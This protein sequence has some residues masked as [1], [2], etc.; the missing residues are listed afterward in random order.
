MH[1]ARMRQSAML[2]NVIATLSCVVGCDNGITTASTLAWRLSSPSAASRDNQNLFMRVTRE[3][4]LPNSAHDL[5]LCVS[6]GIDRTYYLIF[7]ADHDDIVSF[8]EAY[9]GK[10]I[11]EISTPKSY[12]LAFSFSDRNRTIPHKCHSI[13]DPAMNVTNGVYVDEHVG[14]G[15][16]ADLDNNI[17]YLER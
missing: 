9:A 7:S 16:I 6:S 13:I 14:Y 11:D 5:S 4:K 15:M 1:K 8:V 17:V 12:N 3:I 2:V 10:P